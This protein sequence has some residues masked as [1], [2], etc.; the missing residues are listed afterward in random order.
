[1][2]ISKSSGSG[3]V[4]N[5]VGGELTLQG[6]AEAFGGQTLE[7]LGGEAGKAPATCANRAG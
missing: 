1:M 5:S 3:G 6:L 2:S 7:S 4:S